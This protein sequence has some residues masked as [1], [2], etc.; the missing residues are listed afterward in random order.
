LGVRALR[1][2]SPSLEIGWKMMAMND[3]LEECESRQ[4]AVAR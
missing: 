2:G 3:G 1:K 4:E